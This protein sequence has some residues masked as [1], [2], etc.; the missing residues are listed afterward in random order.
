VTGT[1]FLLLYALVT[2]RLAKEAAG[3]PP[4]WCFVAAVLSLVTLPP[5]FMTGEGYIYDPL[6]LAFA[7]VLTYLIFREWHLRYLAVFALACFS[8]ETTILFALSYLYCFRGKL[9][10]TRLSAMMAAQIALF[11]GIYIGLL[12]IFS[13]NPGV[14]VEHYWLDQFNSMLEANSWPG[15]VAIMAMVLLF[16]IG[17]TM[18][19]PVLRSVFVIAVPLAALFLYGGWPREYRI[20][21]EI[22][23]LVVVTWTIGAYRLY[24]S[25]TRSAAV[26]DGARL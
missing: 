18:A 11:A 4:L 13:G 25:A 21:F 23:P 17:I 22:W 15:L 10:M 9:P 20:F 8:K 26:T 16:A 2:G 24:A 5:F 1:G 7:A 19:H 14:L 12:H 6:V 3:L